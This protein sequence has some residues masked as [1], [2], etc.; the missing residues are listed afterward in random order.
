MARFHFEAEA[1]TQVARARDVV[2]NWMSK[3]PDSLRLVALINDAIDDKSPYTGGHCKRVP[4]LTMML[5]EAVHGTAGGPL[6][7]WR[8]NDADRYEIKIAGL[9]HDCGKITTPVHVVDKT[10]ELQ[11]LFDRIHLLDASSGVLRRDA[12]IHR[13]ERLPDSPEGWQSPV[14]SGV[15]VETGH[16]GAG[17]AHVGVVDRLMGLLQLSGLLPRSLP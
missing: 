11:P 14:R 10:T 2:W 1:A 15:F 3:L 16:V 8:M 17:D 9:L 4:I 6:H 12:A 7:G 13:L 5:A